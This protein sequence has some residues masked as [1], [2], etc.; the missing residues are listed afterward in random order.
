MRETEWCLIIQLQCKTFIYFWY[1]IKKHCGGFLV[2]V[3][4]IDSWT[5]NKNTKKKLL[6]LIDRDGTRTHNLPLR[7][8]APYPLG[9]AIFC[10]IIAKSFYILYTKLIFFIIWFQSIKQVWKP[11]IILLRWSLELNP[12]V[13][14]IR[15]KGPCFY[16][17]ET[18]SENGKSVEGWTQETVSL[19]QKQSLEGCKAQQGQYWLVRQMISKLETLHH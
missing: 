17:W 10:L 11:K 13:E 4:S 3:W 5:L 15:F 16:T 7:R 6:F 14:F 18:R 2:I 9:H 12:C 8:R 1:K 19:D